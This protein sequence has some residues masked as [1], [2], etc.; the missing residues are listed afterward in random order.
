MDMGSV[1]LLITAGVAMV[2]TYCAGLLLLGRWD[3]A[4]HRPHQAPPPVTPRL[5]ASA[6]AWHKER[7]DG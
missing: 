5:A 3:R 4:H 7:P 6:D 1:W 2:A